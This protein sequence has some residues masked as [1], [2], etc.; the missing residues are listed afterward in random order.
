MCVKNFSH[1]SYGQGRSGK[2]GEFE[3]VKKSQV[4]RRGSGKVR[5]FL[6]VLECKK[7]L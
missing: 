6:K 7:V 2:V 4:K 1:G 3:E 5:E